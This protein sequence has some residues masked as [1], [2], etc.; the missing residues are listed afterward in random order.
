VGGKHSKQSKKQSFD[1][2]HGASRTSQVPQVPAP[3]DSAAGDA[4]EEFD[5]IIADLLRSAVEAENASTIAK[6]RFDFETELDAAIDNA[7]KNAMQASKADAEGADKGAAGAAAGG[8]GAADT[9]KAD[10]QGVVSASSV[11]AVPE[12]GEPAAT[13][14]QTGAG[15]SQA[16]QAAAAKKKAAKAAESDKAARA[17]ETAEGSAVFA[18]AG[19]DGQDQPGLAGLDGVDGQAGAD[20]RDD[21]AAA[22][23]DSELDAR[24]ETGGP[25]ALGSLVVEPINRRAIWPL[26]I[27]AIVVFIIV[28]GGLT[29]FNRWLMVGQADERAAIQQQGNDYLNESIALIQ[30]ADS[31]IVA[32]DKASESRVTEEDIPRL[33]ALLDQVGS[34]Q[35]SLDNA[36]EKAVQAKETFLDEEYQQLAQRAQDAAGYRKQM[37]QMSSELTSYDIAAMKSALGLEYTW[38][39]IVE[40]DTDM[41][42]AVEAVTV[43]GGTAAESREYNQQAFDKLVLADE[44][45][46]V[47]GEA[48][49]T[50]DFGTLRA[51][52]NVKKESAELALASDDALLADDYYLASTKNEEFIAKDAEAVVLA[53]NIPSDPLSLIFAAYEEAVNQLRV[54]YKA[55]RSQ[56]A[57]ADVYLR[58]YL[59]VDIQQTGESE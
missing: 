50:A 23:A 9:S 31:V 21:S 44:A 58:A 12:D 28:T 2:S 15:K 53:A 14:K 25:E 20:G 51:Y 22:G 49:P 41:R 35:D 39:L 43:W 24:G 8:K 37:L 7:F 1:T 3:H 48:F 10:A 33:E 40:A 54:D 30:E 57:D 55:M 6:P 29:Y 47:A 46:V 26:F 17:A 4:P 13:K 59:G 18:T 27:C 19:A 36:I 32:L 16:K 56:A 5:S 45:L 52:L 38:G 42:S 11:P 34:V